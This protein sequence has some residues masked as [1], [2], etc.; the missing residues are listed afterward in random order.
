MNN[1]KSKLLKASMAPVFAAGVIAMGTGVGLAV[2]AKADCAGHNQT[3]EL[4]AAKAR[5]GEVIL[6]ASCNP[7]NP[8]AAKDNPCAAHPCNPCAAKDNPCGASNP[9]SADKKN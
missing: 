9:C 8:C 4:P 7:C 2:P 5:G 6:A 3:A 1:R